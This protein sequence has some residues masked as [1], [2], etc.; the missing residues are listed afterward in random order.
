[1]TALN[2]AAVVTAPG[3]VFQFTVSTV[4]IFEIPAALKGSF[5]RLS[6]HDASIQYKFAATAATATVTE[7]QASSTSGSGTTG[8][9]YVLTSNPATGERLEAGTFADF[10][11]DPSYTHF[12]IVA[13]DGGT[14]EVT[15]RK[16]AGL[17]L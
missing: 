2:E 16:S 14:A 12:G 1:M 6:V 8:D 17:A 9:P 5:V 15:I 7:D 13:E 11:I 3:T 10:V 4:N